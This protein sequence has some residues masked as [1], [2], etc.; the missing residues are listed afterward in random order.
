MVD[1]YRDVA[2]LSAARVICVRSRWLLDVPSAVPA[3]HCR[4]F[5]QADVSI[6][7]CCLDPSSGGIGQERQLS[8]PRLFTPSVRAGIGVDADDFQLS[9]TACSD[10]FSFHLLRCRLQPDEAATGRLR[11]S[12]FCGEQTRVRRAPTAMNWMQ[13]PIRLRRCIT[14]QSR[15]TLRP[16]TPMSSVW[17]ALLRRNRGSGTADGS[18]CIPTFVA[19][20]RSAK[21]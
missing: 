20:I 12:I 21:G 15:T 4:L 8:A 5:E 10:R 2:E 19:T 17:F 16:Q 11:R 18:A 14:V 1:V 9:P 13:L 6:M 7:F 3:R